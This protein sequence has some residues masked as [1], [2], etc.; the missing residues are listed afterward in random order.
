M[1]DGSGLFVCPV[2]RSVEAQPEV[3]LASAR[4]IIRQEI[5]KS[6][7]MLSA[8]YSSSLTVSIF[9]PTIRAR[10]YCE[11]RRYLSVNGIRARLEIDDTAH[12]P[13]SSFILS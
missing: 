9:R 7:H 10:P 6:T 8:G 4:G 11:N 12:S 2:M 13:T 3:R 5:C 1:D